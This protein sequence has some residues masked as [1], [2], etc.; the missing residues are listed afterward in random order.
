MNS[1]YLWLDGVTNF[2]ASDSFGGI[3]LNFLSFVPKI[4]YFLV[5]CLLSVVDFFQV[6]FRK[7]AGL[8]P[9]IIGGEATT[10]D[11]IYK[12]ISD[13][14]FTAKY[15]AINTAFWAIIVLGIFMLVVTSIIAILRL[16]YKPD[17]DKGNSKAGVITNFVKALFSFA[18]VPVA[19]IF[20]MFLSNSLIGVIDTVTNVSSSQTD[21]AY[22]YFDQWTGAS[23]IENEQLTDKRNP[24]Y[25]A[26]D[27]FGI[28]IPTNTEPFSG[29]VFK[30]SAY[31]SNRFRKYGMSY[32]DDINASGTDMGIFK[33]GQVTEPKQA[34]N[35]IDT[36]FAICARMKGTANSSVTYSM[37]TSSISEE[38]YSPGLVNFL[39]AKSNLVSFS[40]YNTELVWYFYDL[41]TF[42]YI[43][44]F[45]AILV[46]A[47]LYFEFTLALMARLF[48]I[49]GLFLF[50]PIPI[51]LMPLDNGGTLEG[52]RKQFVGKFALLVIMVFG[53]NI[54][55]PLLTIFQEIKFFGAPVIDYI[56]N[57][58]FIIAALN[59]VKSLNSIIAEFIGAKEAYKSANEVAGT[60]TSSLS[61]G[62]NKTMAA[63]KFLGHAGMGAA[64]IGAGAAVLGGKIA[65]SGFGAM[66]RGIRRLG[67]AGT[68]LH[69]RRAANRMARRADAEHAR[70]LAYDHDTTRAAFDAM[71]SEERAEAWKNFK[72]SGQGKDWIREHYGSTDDGVALL[73]AE[74]A[75][76]SGNFKDG[77]EDVA[78]KYFHD[79]RMFD[80]M[81]ADGDDRTSE[82]Y[83]EDLKYY[84]SLSDEE[85][86][87][88]YD[89]IEM[90]ARETQIRA[91]LSS[92]QA[93]TDQIPE[94]RAEAVARRRQNRA[95]RMADR[96]ARIV[97]RKRRLERFSDFNKKHVSP[98]FGGMAGALG[99]LFGTLPGSETAR[100]IVKSTRPSKKGD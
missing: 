95:R 73:E 51:A 66:G 9:I 33:T 38:F 49:A 44:A 64:K 53:L 34:A 81:I 76:K 4:I 93:E 2:F 99:E 30:A 71:S 56:V 5:A 65:G 82:G 15:P 35:I 54:I 90:T 8:D 27:V 22:Q 70:A 83:R 42:N 3:I 6:A 39:G 96:S 52:W 37:D 19:C 62:V 55:S 24:S 29:M 89:G 10:G 77:S 58:L 12:I 28:H 80:T 31:S 84:T 48:E 69:R 11:S 88:Y 43:V 46:I 41:W 74:R 75:F 14:L 1:L 47:K 18:I 21:E 20:G 72:D 23:G 98:I 86:A 92:Y 85:K 79:K 40:K 78:L 59:A 50:A 61:A 94:R 32:L 68:D 13:A 45:V 7:L 60:T 87:R 36:G 63:G 57:T 91:E 16:E 97:K 17:K 26:Y 25:M 67:E 100:D